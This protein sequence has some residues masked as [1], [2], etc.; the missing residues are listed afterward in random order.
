MASSEQTSNAKKRSNLVNVGR[1]GAPHGVNGWVKVQSNTEP[2]D[3]LFAYA[4]L[5]LKTRHGVRTV[6][7]LDFQPHGKAWIAHFDQVNDRDQAAELTN[8]TIAI[9]RQQMAQ[10][11]EGDYYWE[12]L[13]GLRVM[14]DTGDLGEV[15]NLLE[16][17][18]ND[19]LVVKG[20]DNSVDRRERLIPF[21]T[22]QFITS[23]D[24]AAGQMQVDW[25]PE[26]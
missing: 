26:F 17:G 14:A 8:V 24:L 4:P 2:Q 21:V 6:K 20:D 19:V 9:E 11:D 5:W 25:D 7:L 13:I 12:Q 18:A 15:V 23:I 16:T 1:I 22:D 3:N 10:L